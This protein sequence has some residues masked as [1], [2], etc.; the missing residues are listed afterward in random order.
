MFKLARSKWVNAYE[1]VSYHD[2]N[3]SSED[4]ST[5]DL[6]EGKVPVIHSVRVLEQQIKDRR[7]CP[8]FLKLLFFE[9]ILLLF[10]LAA[11]ALTK[12]LIADPID[13]FDGRM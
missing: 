4:Q 2:H 12:H 6:L 13:D 8:F 7:R 3:V 11:Y 10:L 9:N 5:N 1:P